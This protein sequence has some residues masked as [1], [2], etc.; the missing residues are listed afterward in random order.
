MTTDA[1][2]PGAPL[3]V[4]VVLP[5]TP[6][7]VLAAAALREALARVGRVPR[8]SEAASAFDALWLVTRDRPSL[9]LV[10]ID[11]PDLAVDELVALLRARPGHRGL[12]V[13]VVAPA[14]DE[15]A[16]RR[17]ADVD[18]AALLRTPFDVDA[19]GAALA[20]AGVTGEAAR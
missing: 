10:S 18:A 3:P 20:A 8:T 2:A 16:P 19:V 7:R 4:L 13:I 12:A 5:S 1:G 6:L 9:A 15:C 14:A 17:A 11:L